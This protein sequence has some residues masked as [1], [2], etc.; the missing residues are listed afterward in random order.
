M[1]HIFQVQVFIFIY[2]RQDTLT[3][4]MRQKHE[5]DFKSC[6]AFLLFTEREQTLGADNLMLIQMWDWGR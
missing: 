2:F 1:R 5:D 3:Q 6:A 4:S